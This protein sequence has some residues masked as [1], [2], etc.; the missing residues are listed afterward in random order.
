[1]STRRPPKRWAS[2]SRSRYWTAPRIFS[3]QRG[4]VERR[5]AVSLYAFVGSL[6]TGLAF[7]LVALGSYVTVRVLD[8]PDLTVEGSFPLG[9]AV[10][11]QLMVSGFDPWIATLMATACGCF[12]GSITAFLNLKMRI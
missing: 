5:P 6:E 10:S 11:A 7:A 1:M 9:A 12:A 2:P 8:F 4:A 3:D